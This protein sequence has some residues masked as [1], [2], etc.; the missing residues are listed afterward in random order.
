M[1]NEVPPLTE[2]GRALD[3]ETHMVTQQVVLLS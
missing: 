3:A 2:R 1:A